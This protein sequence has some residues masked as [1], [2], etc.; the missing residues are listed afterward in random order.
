M[1]WS[2]AAVTRPFYAERCGN[3]L[4]PDP[5]QKK[6]VAARKWSWLV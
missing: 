5:F 3:R 1:S 4:L 2:S 6:K